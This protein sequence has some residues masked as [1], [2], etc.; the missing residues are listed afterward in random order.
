LIRKSGST[1]RVLNLCLLHERHG[2]DP[3]HDA[4]PMFANKRMNKAIVIKHAVR[5]NEASL[6]PP[7]L[8]VATKIVLPF[9]AT[10]L[11][12]G[13]ASVFVEQLNQDRV[14]REAIGGHDVGADFDRDRDVMAQMSM[15]PS[16]DPFLLRERLARSGYKVARTYF[17][18]AEA[19]LAR[20]RGFVGEE[21]R[22]LAELA[23]A[24]MGAGAKELSARLADKLLNDE[25]DVAL[26]PLRMTLRL[27]PQEHRE[28]F[29]AWKGFLYY[30]WVVTA[31]EPELAKVSK[32]LLSLRLLRATPE[33]KAQLDA[34]RQRIIDLLGKQMSKVRGALATYDRAFHD[35]VAK[36]RAMAFREFLLKAPN[37]FLIIGEHV[38]VVSHINSFW[39]FRFPEGAPLM[40]EADE[41]FELFQ[42]FE[43]SLNTDAQK[44]KA[45]AVAW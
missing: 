26:E 28:G 11:R 42:G 3:E 16:L 17:D 12:L 22:K 37:M 44:P 45:A 29:F 18:V 31:L 5:A 19:D 9:A 21:I 8:R 34:S 33:D 14:L 6:F 7:G 15:L 39:R 38:G 4:H 25:N 10:D 30:K 40:M 24:D 20:M 41:G 36:G 13:G 32:Q 43:S 35:L 27:S 23:F 2:E 1:T